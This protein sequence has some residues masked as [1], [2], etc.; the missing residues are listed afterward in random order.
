MTEEPEHGQAC[1]TSFC[2]SLD[3][4]IAGVFADGA[5]VDTVAALIQEAEATARAAG[6]AAEQAVSRLRERLTEVQSAE[7]DDRRRAAFEQARAE[8]DGLAAGPGLPAARR[9]AR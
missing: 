2:A 9:A 4:R 8:R 7:E 1:K 3:D 5:T 6:D